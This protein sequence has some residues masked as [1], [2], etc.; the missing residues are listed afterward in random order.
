[1]LRAVGE[2][3]RPRVI[4]QRTAHVSGDVILR[5]VA[6]WRVAVIALQPAR[7]RNIIITTTMVYIII[8]V[9][10]VVSSSISSIMVTGGT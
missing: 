1:M 3:R 5:R 8:S 10:V 4:G 2:C 9:V 7:I 6:D